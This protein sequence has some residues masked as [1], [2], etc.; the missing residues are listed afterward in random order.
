MKKKYFAI[1]KTTNVILVFDNMNDRDNYVFFEQIVHPDCIRASYRKI[2]HLVR[3]K[4][5]VF[6]KRFG[7]MIIL[8]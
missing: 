8:V 6:D 1:Y 4:S 5:A 3:G 2:K 7:C